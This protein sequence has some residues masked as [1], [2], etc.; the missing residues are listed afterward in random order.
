MVEPLSED[1]KSRLVEY[2]VK[3]GADLGF[4]KLFWRE[5]EPLP[6]DVEQYQKFCV[7]QS[8]LARGL[9][10]IEASTQSGI[11]VQSIHSW[12]H[13]T[14]LPKLAHFLTARLKY[15]EPPQGRVWLNL[16]HSH[17]HGIPLGQFIRVPNQIRSWEDVDDV[18]QQIRPIGEPSA[19]FSKAYL[20]GFLLGMIIGDAHKPK[21][22]RGHRHIDLVLSMKYETNIKIGEFTSH[23]ANQFGLRMWRHKDK[24]KTENKPHG[25]FEWI[26]QS[27]PFIDWIFNVGIGLNDGEHTT[28]DPIHLDWA[29][30]SPA[31]FRVGLIQGIAE[32]DGSVSIASQTVEFWV[33]PDWDFMIRLLASFGLRAFRNREAVSLVKS[34]AID[35]FKVPVFAPQLQTVRYQRLQLMA[36]TR[37]LSRDQRLPEELRAEITRLAT[38][39]HSV[40]QIVELIAQTRGLLV[41]FEA[42][43]RWAK[44][45]KRVGVQVGGF[46]PITATGKK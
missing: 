21:Q 31:D 35:S 10:Q 1:L 14:S 23:C 36:T 18:L 13:L 34:Q 43:Q 26:S 12:K 24:P 22:G 46:S 39:G 6:L 11:N 25:F 2:V 33:I 42:A 30:D 7:A 8:L 17:G 37:K 29:F 16:E 41:S 5:C 28:Y 38:E 20:F 4:T 44:K 32:S 40:P 19:Q 45:T 3:N 9:K 27:S 15:G